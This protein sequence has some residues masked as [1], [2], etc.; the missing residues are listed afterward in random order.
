MKWNTFL[1]TLEDGG[2]IKSNDDFIFKSNFGNV[3]EYGPTLKI[4]GFYHSED[5]FFFNF[6]G[7]LKKYGNSA[8]LQITSH[9]NSDKYNDDK[10]FIKIIFSEMELS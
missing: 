10:L 8:Q 7:Q 6:I 4:E 3:T 5:N 2:L 1:K 9:E